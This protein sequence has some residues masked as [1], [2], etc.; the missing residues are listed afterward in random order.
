MYLCS[1]RGGSKVSYDSIEGII[2]IKF[3]CK[4]VLAFT[5]ASRR[6][7]LPSHLQL[8]I[9]F[10]TTPKTREDKFCPVGQCRLFYSTKIMLGLEGQTICDKSAKT[11]KIN[12]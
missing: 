12:G 2:C 7:E 8:M 10:Y 3:L 6:R 9:P 4:S 1:G 11:E 5:Y